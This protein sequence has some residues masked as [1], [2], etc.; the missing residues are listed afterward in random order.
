MS[1]AFKIE[2]ISP[3]FFGV[4]QLRN[5]QFIHSV[6]KLLILI[7]TQAGDLLKTFNFLD[8]SIFRTTSAIT[9]VIAIGR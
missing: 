2:E 1:K 3:W 5:L 4:L 8:S 6:P 7:C 9:G